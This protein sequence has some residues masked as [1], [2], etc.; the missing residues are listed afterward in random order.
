MAVPGCLSLASWISAKLTSF[1]LLLLGTPVLNT[2][3]NTCLRRQSPSSAG[4]GKQSGADDELHLLAAT[5]KCSSNYQVLP[6]SWQSRATSC[7]FACFFAAHSIL[8]YVALPGDIPSVLPRFPSSFFLACHFAGEC[9]LALGAYAQYFWG[10]M[11][12]AM[13]AHCQQTWRIIRVNKLKAT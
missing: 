1:F 3:A 9:W 4:R 5:W 11:S 10:Q 8:S 7:Q 2:L 13:R 12:Q 6:A